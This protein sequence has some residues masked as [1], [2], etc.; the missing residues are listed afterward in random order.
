MI[1]RKNI[2]AENMLRFRTKNLVEQTKVNSSIYGTRFGTYTLQEMAGLINTY[3]PLS[4]YI[5]ISDGNEWLANQRA[6]S[7]SQFFSKNVSNILGVPYNSEAVEIEE[8][9]VLGP[10]AENQYVQGTLYAILEKPGQPEQTYKYSLL[11]NFYEVDGLPHIIVTKSGKGT[12]NPRTSIAG[13]D[14]LAREYVN[15]FIPK[16][17]KDSKLVWKQPG[18]AKANEYNKA[19]GGVL[20]IMIPIASGPGY[21]KKDGNALY[22]ETPEQLK[23]MHDFIDTYEDSSGKLTGTQ[24][25]WIGGDGVSMGGGGTY[26]FGSSNPLNVVHLPNDV[27]KFPKFNRQTNTFIRPET[28]KIRSS[29]DDKNPGTGGSTIAGTGTKPE[30]RKIGEFKFDKTMFADNM[31]GIQNTRELQAKIQ[32][33]KK[34]YDV[35]VSANIGFEVKS[36]S[37][38]VRGYSSSDAANNRTASGKPDHGWGINWPAEKWITK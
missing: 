22:F 5:A 35:V 21:S 20:A 29:F 38:L 18:I 14:Q 9:K 37:S 31:I 2:L 12:P 10:G 19:G 27:S 7:L 15:K 13:A 16:T 6:K 23:A 32:E 24:S 30:T 8:A 17:P 34:A 33:I 4:G 11:Y 26:V 28:V 1:K 36:I 3:N 25:I